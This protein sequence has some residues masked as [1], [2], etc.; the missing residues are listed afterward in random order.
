[1]HAMLR[2]LFPRLTAQPARG[3]DLFA[4]VT[5]EARQR[6]WYVEGQVPDSLDGRFAVLATVTALVLVRLENDADGAA[7][8]ALTERFV[9]VMEAEH[10]ELGLG[11]PALGRK[12]RKLVSALGRRVEL[13]RSAVDDGGFTDATRKSLDLD[14]E[15]AT[16][17]IEHDS[18]ALRG[19]WGRLQSTTSVDL[20]EGSFA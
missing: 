7:S 4:A 12:V 2:F 6:H 10:R 3:A 9:T 17:A 5:D 11:D 18:S 15:V 14:S 8:V 20:A 1:M 13:W 19:L 16:A